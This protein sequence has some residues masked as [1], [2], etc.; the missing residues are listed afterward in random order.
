MY[1]VAFSMAC[2]YNVYQFYELEMGIIYILI[3]IDD[4]EK[5]MMSPLHFIYNTFK[6]RRVL[7]AGIGDKYEDNLFICLPNHQCNNITSHVF[8]PSGVCFQFYQ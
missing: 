4:I 2:V 6:R 8:Y 7:Y 5:L 3:R 1:I